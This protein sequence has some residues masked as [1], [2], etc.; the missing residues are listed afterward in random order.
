MHKGPHKYF[1][2]EVYSGQRDSARR[3]KVLQLETL[4][5]RL[6]LRWQDQQADV[7]GL[8]PVSDVTQVVGAAALIFSAGEEGTRKQALQEAQVLVSR[9]AASCPNLARLARAGRLLV[10]VLDRSQAPNTLFQRLVAS[11]LVRLQRIPEE[12][13]SLAAS[14]RAL[15]S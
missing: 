4:C 7:E 9:R 1:L 15:K 8:P 2:A 6:K 10:L 13:A 3:D 12:L 14:V 11:H 5:E